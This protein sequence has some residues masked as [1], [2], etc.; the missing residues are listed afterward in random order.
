MEGQDHSI[1]IIK[2]QLGVGD[3]VWVGVRSSDAPKKGKK[4]F[5]QKINVKGKEETTSRVKKLGD[6]CKKW[7][8]F[9]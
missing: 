1:W 9:M 4:V 8:Y 6:K 2:M 7:N 5:S 3:Y